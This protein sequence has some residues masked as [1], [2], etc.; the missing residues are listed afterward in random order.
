MKDYKEIVKEILDLNWDSLDEED[1]QKVMILSGYSALEF[2]DSLRLTLKLYPKNESLKEMA[3]EELKVS[4]L[5]FGDYNKRGDHSEFLWHFI[6]KYILTKKFPNLKIA[7]ENYMARVEELS[8]EVRV[9]SIVSREKEL[10]G[11]FTRV[12]TAEK[13]AIEGLPE[14]KYYLERHIFLDSHEGGHADMLNNFKVD[15]KV[16]DFYKIRLEMYRNVPKL[17]VLR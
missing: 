15:N 9:M 4:N 5:S 8:P 11:I 16:S 12:L 17:F 2:A 13:W 10:P 7:G 3:S 14:F 1:L 6:N